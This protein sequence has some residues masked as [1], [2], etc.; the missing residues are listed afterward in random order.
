MQRWKCSAHLGNGPK[1]GLEVPD[2][3]CSLRAQ[4]E[5]PYENARCRLV[6]MRRVCR[7]NER[8]G[9]LRELDDEWFTSTL[10]LEDLSS[11]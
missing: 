1:C 3:R 4:C 6:V 8:N 7:T 2:E 10:I 5:C 11:R 9:S